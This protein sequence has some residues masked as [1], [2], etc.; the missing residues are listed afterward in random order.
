[1]CIDGWLADGVPAGRANGRQVSVPFSLPGEI[2]DVDLEEGSENVPLR[3]QIVSV[4]QP[5][6][7]RVT[8]AC[9]HFG[10]CGGCEL[11]HV[12]Y[13]EQL[14][15]KWWRL[16]VSMARVPGATDALRDFSRSGG[17]TDVADTYGFRHKVHFV[18]RSNGPGR[19]RLGHFARHSRRFVPVDECPVHAPAG[20]DVATRL[21]KL[22]NDVGI[23]AEPHGPL[24]HVIVRV[25]DDSE[26]VGITLVV[27]QPDSRLA[28]IGRRLS[29]MVPQVKFFAIN[30]NDSDGPMLTSRQLRPP[31]GGHALVERV[32]GA[33]FVLSPLAFFQT[34][35]RAARLLVHEVVSALDTP[36]PVRILDLYAGVGLFSIPL[37]RRGHRV[38]AV[39]GNRDAAADGVA[40]ARLNGLRQSSCRVLGMSE[41]RALQLL[42]R[43]GA[44]FDAVILDPPR[45]GCRAGILP[46][47]V[48]RL[49]PDRVVYVSCDPETLARDLEALFRPPRQTRYTLTSIQPVDMFPH[50]THVESVSVLVRTQ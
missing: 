24:R 27:R 47:L 45:S 40:S 2:V 30:V 1:M 9:R 34:N 39:E 50:T 48:D 37:A 33:R 4:V 41:S 13:R 38:V 8:P 35:V 42:E 36:S 21:V 17:L 32:D 11:Q 19:V 16:N 44:R 29:R 18:L 43:E 7:E 12:S 22:L 46:R 28:P 3:G 14:R 6:P 49:R 25:A 23:E 5:S 20:N 26:N 15:M 10:T 31:H